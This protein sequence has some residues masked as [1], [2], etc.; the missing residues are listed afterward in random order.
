MPLFSY[1]PADVLTKAGIQLEQYVAI[2]V[3]GGSDCN[4]KRD[5]RHLLHPYYFNCYTYNHP[6]YSRTT[7]HLSSSSWSKHNVPWLSPG[8]NNGL[9]VVVLTGSGMMT[10]NHNVRMLPGLYD[11]GTATAGAD[12]A[13]VI[14][15]PP[16]VVPL[17]LEEGFDVPS[18]FS[19]SLGVRPKRNARIG[20]PY[21]NCV[22]HNPLSNKTG[23]GNGLAGDHVTYRQMVCQQMCTQ[24]YVAEECGCLDEALPS[25]TDVDLPSCSSSDHFPVTCQ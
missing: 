14:I 16:N 9:S 11:I 13:R 12:G 20:P 10:R 4:I 21:G 7:D 1:V 19:V 2:C 6:L 18:G 5:F 8:L 25:L 23:T 22:D 17:P 15:H 3:F 24:K